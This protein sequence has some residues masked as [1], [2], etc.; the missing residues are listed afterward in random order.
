MKTENLDFLAA[1]RLLKEK[2][3][4]I[5]RP[6]FGNGYRI[7]LDY[8]HESITCCIYDIGGCNTILRAEDVLENDWEHV[9]EDEK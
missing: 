4:Y 1:V 3:G 5:K 2:G 7:I 8:A 6:C 9:C